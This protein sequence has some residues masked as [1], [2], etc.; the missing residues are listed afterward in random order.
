MLILNIFKGYSE[1][2]NHP[3]FNEIDWDELYNLNMVS[4]LSEYA[5]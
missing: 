5:K 4:P 1:I 2:K 3:F